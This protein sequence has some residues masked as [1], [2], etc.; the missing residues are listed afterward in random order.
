[1]PLLFGNPKR[2]TYLRKVQCNLYSILDWLINWLFWIGEGCDAEG[3]GGSVNRAVLEW[4]EDSA[5][6]STDRLEQHGVLGKVIATMYGML[7]R[8]LCWKGG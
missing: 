7:L 6:R 5:S 1:L 8:L 4:D 2:F 3:D